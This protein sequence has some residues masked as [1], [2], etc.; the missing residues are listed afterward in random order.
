MIYIYCVQYLNNVVTSV[1][2]AKNTLD[3]FLNLA[4]A[5]IMQARRND[6]GMSQADW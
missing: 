6:F 4:A 2:N 1:A 5:A 3:S